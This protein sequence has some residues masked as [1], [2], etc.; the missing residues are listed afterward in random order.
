[1]PFKIELEEREWEAVR[2]V[3]RALRFFAENRMYTYIDRI[4]DAYSPVVAVAAL[5]DALRALRSEAARNASIYLPSEDNVELVIKLLSRNRDLGNVL[6]AL[7]LAFRP[8]KS[9]EGS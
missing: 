6:A 3:A 4:A 2:E 5:K 9:D 1:M 8:K 7:A